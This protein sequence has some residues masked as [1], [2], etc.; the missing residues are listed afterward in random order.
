MT[1][2]PVQRP[3]ALLAGWLVL[4]LA[5]L[6]PLATGC[7]EESRCGPK[8]ATVTNVVDGDTFDLD[9]GTR[10]RLLMVDTPETTMGHDDCY[11][12]EAK[13]FALQTLLGTEVDLSYDQVCED[14]YGRTLAYVSI[15]GREYNSL[16]VE[17]GYACVL[18]IPPNGED[19]RDEFETLEYIAQSGGVGLWGACEDV[20]CD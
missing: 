10:I 13:E 4:A 15:N 17:R 6:A 18:Y 11:G 3:R 9:D 5:L 1:R 16:L 7:E 20:T 14:Q 8:H 19:R 2:V 12:Q